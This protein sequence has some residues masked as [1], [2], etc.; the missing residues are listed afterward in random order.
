VRKNEDTQRREILY[1]GMVQGVGFRFTASRMAARFQVTG[2][3]ENLADGRVR[4]V[5]EGDTP[6]IEGF[7]AAIQDA[8]GAYIDGEEQTTG[9]PTYTFRSFSVR[10]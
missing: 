2:F 5:A 4:L 9:A 3:V 7:L 1:R 6:Q 8:L 10:R